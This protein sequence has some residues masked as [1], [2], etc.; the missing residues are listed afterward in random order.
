ML[1]YPDFLLSYDE[2][3]DDFDPVV[4]AYVGLSFRTAI[5]SHRHA[6]ADAGPHCHVIVH[7]NIEAKLSMR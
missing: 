1:I 2:R 5:A 7:T 3:G 4:V 6:T